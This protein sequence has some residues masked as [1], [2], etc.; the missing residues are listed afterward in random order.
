MGSI[1][2]I[3]SI[4][5]LSCM[6]FALRGGKRV[7]AGAMGAAFFSA[8]YAL[9]WAG[10]PFMLL[11]MPASLLAT[12][13]FLMFRYR[14]K[15][16]PMAKEIFRFVGFYFLFSAVFLA[17][18]LTPEGLASA[19][20]LGWSSLNE[21]SLS[22]FDIWPNIYVTVGEAT[23]IGFIKL[24]FLTG[25]CVTFVVALL[26]ILMEG[27]KAVKPEN[28]FV[29]LRFIFFMCFSIPLLF[30]SL[31]TERFSILFVMPLAVFVGF[32][33]LRIPEMITA[34]GQRF[35]KS[36]ILKKIFSPSGAKRSSC[37]STASITRFP[38][39]RPS[40]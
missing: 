18:F 2:F 23:G 38:A 5:I 20:R 16:L 26:G 14:D 40:R 24:I 8:F 13:F 35:Q 34:L 27:K 10:W 39:P 4:L 6:F 25:N 3:I 11:L 29:Q 1:L 37:P 33:A 28:V 7:V 30:M 36:A 15:K 22:K 21:Y 9:F 32:A 19:A 31:K 17:V 12:A